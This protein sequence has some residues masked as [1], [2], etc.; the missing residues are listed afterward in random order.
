M[1]NTRSTSNF[2]NKE[3]CNTFINVF[4][5]KLNIHVILNKIKKD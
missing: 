4:G 3:V 1:P 2:S 5:K